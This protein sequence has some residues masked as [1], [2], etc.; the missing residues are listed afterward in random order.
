MKIIR[1]AFIETEPF[2]STASFVFQFH[3]DAYERLRDAWLHE[4][5]RS[6]EWDDPLN[7]PYVVVLKGLDTFESARLLADRCLNHESFVE[8]RPTGGI[9]PFTDGALKKVWEA[10]KPRP[11]WFLRV[12]HDLLQIGNT[13]RKEV[14][15]EEFV[16]P[17]IGRLSDAARSTES[18]TNNASDDRL[19]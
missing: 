8:S 11:R 13:E 1:D 9:V 15:D 2:A 6:L 16:E 18:T 17:K 19:A 5:M 10:T 14:L 3:P 7:G 12:L 4:D